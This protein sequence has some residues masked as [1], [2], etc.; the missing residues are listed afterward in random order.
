VRKDPAPAESDALQG[1]TLAVVLGSGL[2][3]ISKSFPE[4]ARRKFQDIPGLEAAC[5]E[6]HAGELKLCRVDNRHCLFVCGRR[7]YYEGQPEQ[8][9][10]LVEYL[11]ALGIRRLLLTS[12][13][14]SLTSG[15][16]PGN[17][18]L[19]DTLLDFQFRPPEVTAGD[20][21]S[22]RRATSL[23]GKLQAALARAAKRAGVALTRGSLACTAGPVYETRSEVMFLQ[24]LG[25]SAVSMSGAA[26]VAAAGRLGIQIASVALLTNWATGISGTR[27]RHADVL[28]RGRTSADNLK[29][30]IVQLIAG[31]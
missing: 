8:I 27:L 4:R 2:G 26:E 12:A 15:C 5:I 17:L 23:D 16:E 1:A 28:E 30:V 9:A 6:G 13:A 31:S 25:I 11:H 3:G 21:R 10:T 18:M 14:G 19:A 20:G 29:R 22:R 24:R 7:H